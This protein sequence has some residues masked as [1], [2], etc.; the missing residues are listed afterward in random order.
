MR[1]LIKTQENL[2]SEELCIVVETQLNCKCEILDLDPLGVLN[3]NATG[4]NF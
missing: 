3:D 2:Q 1:R 4:A